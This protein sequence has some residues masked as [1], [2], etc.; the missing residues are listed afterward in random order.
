MQYKCHDSNGLLYQSLVNVLIRRHFSSTV[1]VYT[2]T[3]SLATLLTC[4]KEDSPKD[5]PLS[6]CSLDWHAR[7]KCVPLFTDFK[8]CTVVIEKYKSFAT[9]QFINIWHLFISSLCGGCQMI[10]FSHA[11]CLIMGLNN[12][13]GRCVLYCIKICTE[14]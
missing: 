10:N 11:E 2:Q 13:K 7:I 9:C 8:K 3:F 6:M 12:C 14:K 1:S 4:R 5:C